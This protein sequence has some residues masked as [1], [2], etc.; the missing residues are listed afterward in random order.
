M[1]A[2]SLTSPNHKPCMLQVQL[3]FST[4]PSDCQLLTFKSHQDICQLRLKTLGADS[5]VDQGGRS[6]HIWE[7]F[8]D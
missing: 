7:V 1:L 8:M 2:C 3:N 6:C 4:S 5:D